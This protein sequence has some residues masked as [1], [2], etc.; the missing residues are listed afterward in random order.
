ME[1]EGI[2]AAELMEWEDKLA[3]LKETYLALACSFTKTK[4]TRERVF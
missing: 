3:A 4:N 1:R 2:M